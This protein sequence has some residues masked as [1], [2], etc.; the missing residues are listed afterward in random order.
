MNRFANVSI[1][2]HTYT[3]MCKSVH[4]NGFTHVCKICSICKSFINF[5]PSQGQVQIFVCIYTL[6]I[7]KSCHVNAK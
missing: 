4:V 5:A 3:H 6:L 2:L 1:Y 7:C